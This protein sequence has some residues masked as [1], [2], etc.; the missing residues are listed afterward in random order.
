[1]CDC[2]CVGLIVRKLFR[3]VARLVGCFPLFGY[4]IGRVFCL[5]VCWL[6]S[7]LFV[8]LFFCWLLG[9]LV[10]W[11]VGWPAGLL[12]GWLVLVA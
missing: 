1:M 8:W 12:V 4:C 5:L 3:P 7:W 2:L 6:Y 9:W 10:N 11:S